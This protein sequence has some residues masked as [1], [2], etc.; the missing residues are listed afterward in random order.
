MADGLQQQQQAATHPML[1]C[2]Q[3]AAMWHVHL[4]SFCAAAVLAAGNDWVFCLPLCAA[5]YA[6]PVLTGWA[7]FPADCKVE[8]HQDHSTLCDSRCWTVQ[9]MQYRVCAGSIAAQCAFTCLTLAAVFVVFYRMRQLL[10]QSLAVLNGAG[11][12]HQQQ[13]VARA[14][15]TRCNSHVV[16]TTGIINTV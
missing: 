11:L 6:A 2:K 13:L 9:V 7:E 4:L 3:Y 5:A 14:P 10:W 12:L 16:R 1:S 15:A 8:W